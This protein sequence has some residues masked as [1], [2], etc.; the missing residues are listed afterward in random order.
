[1]QM[2]T[3]GLRD[4]LYFCVANGRL[5]FLDLVADRYFCVHY[6]TEDAFLRLTHGGR[7]T[8]GNEDALSPLLSNGLL[9]RGKGRPIRS[10]TIEPGSRSFRPDRD[11]AISRLDFID[12]II[13]Q[14]WA[15]QRLKT[16]SLQRVLTQVR[17]RKA[18]RPIKTQPPTAPTLN[19][20]LLTRRVIK[21]RDRCLRWSVAMVDYLA[22]RGSYPELILGVRMSPFFAHAWVQEGDDIL[23]D[24]VDHVSQYTPIL[25]I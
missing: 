8:A 9:L 21:T 18:K 6:D 15:A 13:A 12:G 19:A 14:V 7:H 24:D 5:V 1:M 25:V 16:L 2:T 23:N 22:R 17:Q 11:D 10:V 3:Y 20:F 4:E